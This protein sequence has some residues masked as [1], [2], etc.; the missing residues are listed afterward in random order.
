M[1]ELYSAGMVLYK[2]G[3]GN[4]KNKLNGAYYSV[5]SSRTKKDGTKVESDLGIYL[6]GGIYIENNKVFEANVYKDENMKE[7]VNTY[8]SKFDPS[9]KK[10]AVSI[11]DLKEGDYYV[12]IDNEKDIKK[13]VVQKGAIVLENQFEDTQLTYTEVKAPTSYRIDNNSYTFSVGN[14]YS[15]NIIENYRSNVL[16]YIPITGVD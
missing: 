13:Y 14:D 3:N 16:M 6:T 5:Q 12:Q 11:T 4:Y 7:L 2:I 9:F 10:Q 1:N 15:K 8:D